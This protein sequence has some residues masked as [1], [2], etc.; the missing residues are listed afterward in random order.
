MAGNEVS[1]CRGFR[2]ES[3]ASHPEKS[4]TIPQAEEVYGRERKGQRT[5]LPN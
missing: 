3:D 5:K 4:K 2:L 1:L